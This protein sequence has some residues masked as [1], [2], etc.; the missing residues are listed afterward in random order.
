LTLRESAN[1]RREVMFMVLAI[2]PSLVPSSERSLHG[3]VKE[4]ATRVSLETNAPDDLS[5]IGAWLVF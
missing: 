2:K 3:E 1:E 5:V 4:A